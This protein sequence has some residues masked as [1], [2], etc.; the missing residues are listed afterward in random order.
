ME[1]PG[2]NCANGGVK[3]EVLVDDVVQDDQTQYICNPSNGTNGTNATIQTSTVSPGTQCANGGIKIEVLLD[4]VVQPAQT[5]YICNG[6][7]GTNGHDGCDSGFHYNDVVKRC[8]S[9]AHQS[10][11]IP[12]GY[13][14]VPHEAVQGAPYNEGDL[15]TMDAF[16]MSKTPITVAQFTKC[17][18]GGG[19]QYNSNRMQITSYFSS[20]AA[21]K[22]DDFGF[23]CVE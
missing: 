3:I 13:Y 1:A 14:L 21:A 7:N 16:A 17:V 9:D 23:R 2:T 15:L 18:Q 12:A 20:S 4:G 10:I 8:L 22:G 5:K 19:W 11:V 6:N